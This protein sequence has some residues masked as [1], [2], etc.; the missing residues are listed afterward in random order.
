MDER[1]NRRRRRRRRSALPQLIGVLAIVLIAVV[2]IALLVS[3]SRKLELKLLGETEITVEYGE[4]YTDQGLETYFDGE[5]VDAQV[6]IDQPSMDKL[7]TYTIIYTATYD[8]KTATARRTVHLV[9]TQAPVITL[10]YIPGYYLEVGGTYEEEGYLAQDNYDGD[11]TDSVQRKQEGDTVYYSVTDSS[12][13]TVTIE[14]PIVYGDLTAPVITLLGDTT[15]TITA[16]SEF[17]D[18]G[19]TAEDNVD[20][21]LTANVTVTG[22]HDSYLPGEYTYTYTVT[23]A[24][25]NTGTAVRTIIV[26]A[27]EQPDDVVTPDKVIYLTFDDGPSIYT[28]RLLEILKKYNVKVTFFVVGTSALEYLDDIAE[29]GHSIGIHSNTHVYSD[30]YASEDAFFKDFNALYDKIYDYCGVEANLCRFPGGSSNTISKRYCKG[31]MTT[32]TQKV[33]DMGFQYFDWNVDSNDA[34]GAK[35]SEEVYENVIAGIKGKK[36]A[37]VLQHDIFEYSV[38]AVEK[39]IQ[40]GLANGYTFL[41]LTVDSPGAHHPVNN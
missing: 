17:T 29:A 19:Y 28:P 23:D 8:G 38:E 24:H 27:I 30:I 9:D 12:G 3:G 31:I 35:T 41:P 33:R 18:P 1:N 7:G 20:G 2:V 4:K 26:E 6:D 14:R 22:G 36:T 34:G 39:I 11:L 25:G 5:K 37:V 13:N 40:W 21:D 10:L 15:V 16:G 32:L